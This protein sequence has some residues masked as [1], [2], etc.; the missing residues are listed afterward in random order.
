[1]L[2]EAGFHVV[3]ENA[4]TTL[5]ER[6]GVTY[7]LG[8]GSSSRASTVGEIRAVIRKAERAEYQLAERKTKQNVEEIVSIL[9]RARA[10]KAPIRCSVCISETGFNIQLP[11]VEELWA[12]MKE[13]H[14]KYFEA[15]REFGVWKKAGLGDDGKYIV[16]APKKDRDYWRTRTEELITKLGITH[17]RDLTQRLNQEGYRNSS[18]KVMDMGRIW[19]WID[20]MNLHREARGERPLIVAGERPVATPPAEEETVPVPAITESI[21]A[22]VQPEPEKTPAVIEPAKQPKSRYS[23]PRSRKVLPFEQRLTMYRRIGVMMD[24]DGLTAEQVC[25]RLTEE[26]VKMA[27]GLP[28]EPWRVREYYTAYHRMRELLKL[29]K[30]KVTGGS[31]PPPGPEVPEYIRSIMDAEALKPEQKVAALKALIPKLPASVALMLEDPD[32]SAAQRLAIL[33]VVLRG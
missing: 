23:V 31:T 22:Q 6:A 4:K 8:T 10:E 26:G 29:P 33:G 16:P 7:A 15:A 3:R 1:M 25:A 19:G 27:S 12:H 5:F 13:R 20:E 32:L 21:P 11:G 9:D 28:Y 18:G 24:V 17:A 14:P 2:K 30:P